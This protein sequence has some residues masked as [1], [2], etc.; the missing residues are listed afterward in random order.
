MPAG[1]T[2]GKLVHVLD[3]IDLA[4]NNS[5]ADAGHDKNVVRITAPLGDVTLDFV[6][7]TDG[8]AHGAIVTPA[9]RGNSSK[10]TV[11]SNDALS[12]GNGA[13]KSAGQASNSNAAAA[14]GGGN[15]NGN[16]NGIGNG[17]A[18]GLGN[19]NGAA[20]SVAVG[21]GNGNGNAFGV[22]NGLAL[23]HLKLKLKL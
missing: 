18:N 13:A 19:G 5:H 21:N 20:N 2:D 8:L 3:A 11:W 9:D 16:A 1:S 12:P 17:V 23:G 4:H 7:A 10:Q 22:G 6:K 15:G 14:A